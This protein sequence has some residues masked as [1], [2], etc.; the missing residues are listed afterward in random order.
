VKYHEL[1]YQPIDEMYNG[2][3]LIPNV[4]AI[5]EPYTD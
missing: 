4:A 1:D 3:V 5:F 2:D